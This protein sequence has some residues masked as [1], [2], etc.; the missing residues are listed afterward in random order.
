MALIDRGSCSVSLKVDRAAKAG[1]IGVLLGLVASGDASGFSFGGGDTFVPGLVIIQNYANLIKAQLT[2]GNVVNASATPGVS[3]PLVNSVVAS[4]SRGPSYSYQAIK[5]DI[6]APGASVSAVAGSGTGEDVFGGTSGAAPVVAGVMALLRQQYPARVPAELK[7]LLMNTGETNIQVNPSTQP[8]YLAPITRIGGGE[9]R[10]LSAANANTAAWDTAYE[11]GSLSFGYHS[12]SQPV[13]LV[14]SVRIKN[15]LPVSRL[16]NIE[17]TFRYANDEANGAVKVTAPPT[18]RLKANESKTF[19]VQLTIDPSKLPNWPWLFAGGSLGGDASLLDKAEYDGYLHIYDVQDDIHMAWQVLP[20]K[21]AAYAASTKK[22]ELAGAPTGAFNIANTG[23][24]EGNVDV[25]ALTGKSSKV[26]NADLPLPGDNFA[27]I[28]M[29]YVGVRAYAIPNGASVLPVLEFGINTWRPR[30]HPS[31]PAEFDV[32]IDSDKDGKSDYLL[33][34]AENPL[35]QFARTGQTL[36]YVQ[37]LGTTTASAYFYADADLDSGN[38][39]MTVPFAAVGITNSRTISFSVYAFD[40]YFSGA[41]TDAITN[42]Q[43]NPLA[44]KFDA[45]D[46]F[47]VVSVGGSSTVNVQAVTGG[48]TASPSQTGFLLMYRDSKTGREVEGVTVKP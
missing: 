11:A 22:V 5:P 38:M 7:A 36:V 16:Y 9:V 18:I 46:I 43:Y 40:N 10:A 33:F 19:K 28:D 26:P 42:M 32:Y 24:T 25:F 45:D 17:P 29:R 6:G 34:T 13:T 3:V 27:V 47:P 41:L 37:K 39:I 48:A 4:S 21:S 15:Y 30:S 20:H 1:A 2:A 35:G 23:A 44:P 14:R 12:V 8:G 31:Y